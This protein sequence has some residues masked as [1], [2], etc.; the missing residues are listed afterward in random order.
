MMNPPLVLALLLS[1]S[2]HAAHPERHFASGW[3]AVPAQNVSPAPA[4]SGAPVRAAEGEEGEGDDGVEAQHAGAAH[5]YITWKAFQYYDSRYPG[6][7]LAKFIGTYEGMRPASGDDST[8][9]E[10]SY[11]EDSPRENPWG[12]VVSVLRHFWNWRKGMEGGLWGYDPSVNR[13]HKFFTGGYGLDG[14]FDEGWK[15]GEGE[16]ILSLYKKGDKAKAYWYLGHAVHLVEDL[17]VPAHN[18]LWPHPAKNAD[19][20]ETYMKDHHKDWTALP[21]GPVESFADVYPLF[22]ATAQITEG[23]DAGNGGGLLGSD[24][25]VD[26]GDRRAGGFSDAELVGEASVLMPLA[27]KRAAATFKLFYSKVDFEPPTVS[28]KALPDG[29][30]EAEATEALSGLDVDG[31]SFESQALGEKGWTASKG[32]V[33]R[34]EPG[35]RYRLRAFARDGAGNLGFADLEP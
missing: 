10:G 13:A 34:G 11:D 27:F 20:Y 12:D 19:R 14:K 23:F 32:R 4:V 9:I 8:V 16:G 22:L 28:I 6:S 21:E 25:S 24:G 33:F 30:F 7:E 5:M 17:T 15:K 35:R 26:R 18:L 29:S 2:G 31:W 3:T 1:S